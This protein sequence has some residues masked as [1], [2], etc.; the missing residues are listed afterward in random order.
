ME[1]VH[2]PLERATNEP[3]FGQET[4]DDA[5]SED[6]R[7][8]NREEQELPEAVRALTSAQVSV[9]A[10]HLQKRRRTN[11]ETQQGEKGRGDSGPGF[12]DKLEV[13]EDGREADLEVGLAMDVAAMGKCKVGVL[14]GEEI[15]DGVVDVFRTWSDICGIVVGIGLSGGRHGGGGGQVAGALE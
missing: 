6:T 4:N 2:V 3:D 11:F 9:P 10:L 14:I 7:G 5:N 1:G 15:A 13:T 12:S 8:Q